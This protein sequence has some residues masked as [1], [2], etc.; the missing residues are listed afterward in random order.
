MSL[1]HRPM[2]P[3]D[4]RECVRILAAHPI[5]GPRYAEILE[6]LPQ[7]FL[8]LSGLGGFQVTVFE[9]LQGDS[10]RILGG[11][12]ACFVRDDFMREL[13]TPPFFWGP[14]EIV[15][16][17]RRGDSPI[18]SDKEVREAN[19]QGGLN[20][21]VWHTGV[22]PEDLG[23]PEVMHLAVSAFIDVHR[24]YQLKEL[25]EQ[26]ETWEQFCGMRAAGGHFVRPSDGHYAEYF[27]AVE[28]DVANT[29]LMAGLTRE[30]I[31]GYCGASWVSALF[32]YERPRLGLARSEQSLLL[33][34]L[35]GGTDEELSDELGIFL[36]AVKKTWRTIYN[37][38]AARLPDLIMG[39]ATTGSWKQ[40]RGM[41]KKQRVIAYLREHAE[42]LRPI[43]RKLL[44]QI[45]AGTQ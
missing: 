13:K 39:E 45:A 7:V 16:R 32:K 18:L 40:E 24:G 36:S 20:L 15:R 4:A 12:T 22:S 14:P 28:A 29:P 10:H 33:A 27:D 31:Q 11:G 2:R 23:R 34:A 44:T 21:Y 6:E 35:R 37:R 43:S 1:R 42:E 3:K 38:V 5:L 41:E 9:E 25:L 17:L 8:S 19:S 26:A 30:L